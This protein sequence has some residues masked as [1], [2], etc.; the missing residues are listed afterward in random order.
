MESLTGHIEAIVYV[1]P[2]NGFTVA[3]LKEPNKKELTVIVGSLP[4][5]QPGE[6]VIC[7]GTWKI[8]PSHGRQFE[9]SDWQVSIPCDVMGIQ[10]YLESGLVKGIGPVFAKKI[11]TRFGIDTLRIIDESPRRLL[12]IEG[13]GRSKMKQIIDCWQAQRSIREVMLFLRTHGVSPGYAQKIYKTYGNDSIVKV[14]ENPYQLAKDIFGIGFKIADAL[15]QKLGLPLHSKERLSAGLQ[16]VLWELSSEG[17]TCYP[18]KKL[19]PAAKEMLDVEPDLIAEELKRLVE[20]KELVEENQNDEPTIWLKP[21]HAYEQGI[22]ENLRRL[23]NAPQAL[24]AIDV[25][26]A[27]DWVQEQL[28][29]RFA[30]EQEEAIRKALEDKV[31]VITGGPG[32]GKSTITRAIL[33]ISAK[34]TNQILLAAPTGRA[35]KRLSEITHRKAFT[36]HSLL[37]WEPQT[38]GFKRTKENPL[39]ADL[40]IIDEASMIDTQLMFFLLRAIRS[41]ARVIFVGDIDQLPS[42]GAGTVLRDLINSKVVGVT[43]LKEIFR[44]AKGSQIITNAHRIN[45]GEFPFLG[46]DEK[47]DFH[48]IAAETPEAIQQVI[49]ELVSKEIPQKKGFH[50]IDEIQILSPMKRGLIGIEQMNDSLQNLLNPSTRPFFQSGRRLHVRD[51]VMQLSNNYDKKVYNGDIGRI[52]YI[53]LEEKIIQ[54]L[55]D[56]KQ[57]TYD[58]SELDE[59]VLAYAVSVHKYQGSECPCVIIPIHTTHFKLLHRNLLYT[60]VTRGKKQVYLVGTTK[61]IAIAI[62]NDQAAQRYTGL[63]K[64]LTK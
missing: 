44:Q 5:I 35:A 27:C 25:V 23:R 7:Q 13:L 20:K 43:C 2:E 52:E 55:F 22:A 48:F 30:K 51:K 57:V 24:R 50:P 17:H 56:D 19:I 41:D 26:K 59:L 32:T 63:E 46:T 11:V 58:F 61:A 4:S 6:T 54:I 49:L 8:H 64:A 29:I 38:G 31:H 28:H 14:R 9:V 12:E 34:L 15:A 3:R 18:V 10:K 33:A 42:V 39:T 36:L 37:E 45:Q 16:Y 1:Q 47:S 62:H 40:L 60:A 21:F 53:D